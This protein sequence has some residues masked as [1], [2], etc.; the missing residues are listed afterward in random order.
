MLSFILG[1]RAARRIKQFT[2]MTPTRTIDYAGV[3]VDEYIFP[4]SRVPR[5]GSWIGRLMWEIGYTF[6]PKTRPKPNMTMTLLWVETGRL[7]NPVGSHG[8]K[9]PL[10]HAMYE[11]G[12]DG[13]MEKYA[14]RRVA[15]L[16]AKV[17]GLPDTWGV[18]GSMHSNEY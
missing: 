15:E 6:R 7:L 1:D 17:H 8:E 12:P 13:R 4:N 3:S 14:R 18:W 11:P 2:G 5:G 10:F 16:F 9:Y